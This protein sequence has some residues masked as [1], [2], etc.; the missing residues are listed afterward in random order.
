MINFHEHKL[1]QE[2]YVALMDIHE[3]LD[4]SEEGQSHD[5]DVIEG[6]LSS[7]QNVAATIADSLTRADRRVGRD[8]MMQAVGQVAKTRTHLAVAWGR[9]SMDDETFRGIDDKYA[10]LS[11][12]LQT[13]R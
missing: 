3:M 11:E 12:S 9:G 6:L 10:K 7:A 13:F 1:W 4:S 2:S 8:L 5:N